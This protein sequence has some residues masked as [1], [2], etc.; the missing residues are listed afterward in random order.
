VQTYNRLPVALS[1]GLGA[2]VWDVEGK[3]Y[4]DALAGIA[5]NSLGHCHPRGVLVNATAENA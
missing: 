2:R 5:V 1:H 4:I 3:E